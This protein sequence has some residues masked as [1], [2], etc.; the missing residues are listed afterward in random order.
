M[1]NEELLSILRNTPN[2]KSFIL[3]KEHLT[4]ENIQIL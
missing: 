3:E 4:R 2:Q 1:T